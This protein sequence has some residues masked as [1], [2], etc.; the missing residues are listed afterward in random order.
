[1]TNINNLAL[2]LNESLQNMQMQMAGSGGEGMPQQ[3]QGSGEPSFRNM[4]QMQEQLNQMLQQMQQGHQGMPGQTGQ[5]QMSMS[6]AMARMAAEQEAI[7]KELQKMSEQLGREGYGEMQEELSE[8]QK[9]MEQTELDMVRK[10]IG[11]QTL[12]R[13]EEILTRL[14][15]HERAE[16]QREMDERRVGNTANNYEFSNPEEIFEYNRI[17]NKELEMLRSMPA[18]LKPFYRSMVE[19]YFLNMQE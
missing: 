1:M 2:L 18:G 7:R 14:L 4:R 9:E 5:P 13:Q 16:L 6:E 8:L 3:G 12:M 10:E 19:T 11:R 15:E 17:R